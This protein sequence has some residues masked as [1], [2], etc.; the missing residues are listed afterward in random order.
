MPSKIVDEG[1]VIR[2]MTEGR[3]YKWMTEEYLRKYHIKMG[4]S[5]WSNFRRRRGLPRRQARNDDLIPWKVKDE[6]RFAYPLAMLRVEARRREGMELRESDQERLASFLEKLEEEGAVVH[7][8]PETEQGFF[9]VPRQPGDDDLIHKP[10]RK[11]T[12]RR[13]AD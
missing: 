7:Y 10:K 8:E 13:R 12:P 9:L 5:G 6:H 11:T 1:E 4:A 3:S 2:W